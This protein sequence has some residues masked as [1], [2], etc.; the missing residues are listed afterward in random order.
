MARSPAVILADE[1][2]ASLDRASADRLVDDLLGVAAE[3]GSTLIAVTH[4]E[5]LVQSLGGE[6]RLADGGVL[7]A[8]LG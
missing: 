7:E 3:G 2:T 4:D 1:P 8:A 5:R 6:L